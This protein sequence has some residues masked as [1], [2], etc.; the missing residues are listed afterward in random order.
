[1]YR[2]PPP[3]A[4]S[5]PPPRVEVHLASPPPHGQPR[6]HTNIARDKLNTEGGIERQT[7]TDRGR[8]T[9]RQIEREGETDRDG[10]TDSD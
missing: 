6:D 3:S 10:E 4:L 7:D 2:R 1:M 5:L 9:D 8:Q